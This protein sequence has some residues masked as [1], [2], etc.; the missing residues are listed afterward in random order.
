MVVYR[1]MGRCMDVILDV[2]LDAC[3]QS[4][5]TIFAVLNLRSGGS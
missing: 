1:S 4:L 3:L 2:I 5:H